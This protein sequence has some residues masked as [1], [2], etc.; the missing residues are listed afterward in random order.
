MAPRL[1]SNPHGAAEAEPPRGRR[2]HRPYL[3]EGMFAEAFEEPGLDLSKG[4]KLKVV[5]RVRTASI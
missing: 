2:P 4:K 1:S 3:W 5:Y